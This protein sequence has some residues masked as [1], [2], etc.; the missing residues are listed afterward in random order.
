MNYTSTQFVPARRMGIYEPIHQ[1]SMWE[2]FK[3]KT[4]LDESPPSILDVD[5][6]LDNQSEDT[7][8]GTVGPSNKYDQEASKPDKV[9]RRLAQN[10]EAARKS[11]LRKKAYVQQLE[12]SNLRL[13]Q[14]EQE[15]QHVRQQG[16]NAGG[17]LDTSQLSYAGYINP[18]FGVLKEA[19]EKFQKTIAAFEMEYEHWV[20]ER[21]RQISVLR[22]ALQCDNGDMELC[23]L[24][25]CGIRH[26]FDL[27]V[28]KASAAK[29]DVFYV[30]SGMWTTPAERFFSWIGG[31]RPSEILKVISPHIEPFTEQQRF[32]VCNLAQSCEQSEDALS[33]GMRRLHIILAETIAG[34]KLVEDNYVPHIRAAIDKLD[35]LVRFVAQII[36]GKKR[37]SS[38]WAFLRLAKQPGRYLH[39]GSILNAYGL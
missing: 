27:S 13:I 31:F 20:E 39:W 3:G 14:L 23:L 4:C 6:K 38:F 21:N 17:I 11:R 15:L 7:S 10:R 28:M 32:D 29:A 19:P 36:F 8:N 16:L 30:M 22:N 1:M 9:L 18:D 2:D 25:E 33:Q 24:I 37:Y 12:N 26:Y 5:T 34:K 35:A